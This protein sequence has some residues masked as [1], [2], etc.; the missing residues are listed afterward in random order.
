M[1]P[2]VKIQLDYQ[3][4]DYILWVLHYGPEVTDAHLTSTV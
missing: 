2:T 4:V 1:L 3:Q